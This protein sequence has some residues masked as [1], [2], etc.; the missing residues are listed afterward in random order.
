MSIVQNGP[1]A[2]KRNQVAQY[3]NSAFG[4]TKGVIGVGW[5]FAIGVVAV[6][7]DLGA[8]LCRSIYLQFIA[9]FPVVVVDY[10]PDPQTIIDVMD[11]MIMP[12]SGVI[13]FSDS[14][15]CSSGRGT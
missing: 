3:N 2:R 1:I 14:R 12:V 10:C 8:W 7:P 11:S 13:V 15:H 5:W 6:A 4:Q 9:I